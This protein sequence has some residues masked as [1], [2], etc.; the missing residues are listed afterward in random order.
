MSLSIDVLVDTF[1][2]PQCSGTLEWAHD[3][4]R[5]NCRACPLTYPVSDG[6]PVLRID[7]ATTRASG[8]VHDRYRSHVGHTQACAVQAPHLAKGLY[9]RHA[10][11]PCYAPNAR[12][13][14]KACKT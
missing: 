12:L 9:P 4:V 3:S 8:T 6:V 11:F 7:Y 5:L 1:M 14:D 13:A 2:C 10:S